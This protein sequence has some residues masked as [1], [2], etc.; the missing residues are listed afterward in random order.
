LPKQTLSLNNRP[1]FPSARYVLVAALMISIGGQWALLQSAAWVGMAVA[2]SV[3][4]GSIAKGVSKTFDGDHPCALC[5]MV[6]EGQKSEKKLP[7]KETPPRKIE[8]FMT[9][10]LIVL[11]PPL[12]HDLPRPMDEAAA[13]RLFPPPVPPPRCGLL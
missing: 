11:T 3:E 12:G 2:Y 7:S 5:K 8:L 1:V 4:E 13:P 6:E 9:A 10:R